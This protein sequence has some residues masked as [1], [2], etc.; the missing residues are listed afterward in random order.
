MELIKNEMLMQTKLSFKP[1][2][3]SNV[4][5]DYWSNARGSRY[6]LATKSS[7]FLMLAWSSGMAALSRP[8]S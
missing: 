1:H 8:V 5:R 6:M 4:A 3:C 2:N 7:P